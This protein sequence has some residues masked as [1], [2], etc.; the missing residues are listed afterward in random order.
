MELEQ[1]YLTYFHDLYRYLFSLTRNHSEAEDLVQ[2]TF[3]KA[4]LMLLTHDIKEIKPWLFK[5]GY[6]TFVDRIRKEKRN[7]V[8]EEFNQVD[9]NNPE[10]V[11]VQKDSFMELLRYLDHIKP[12]EKQAILLCDLHECTY[13]QAANI[14]NLKLN[15]LKSHLTRGRKKMREILTKEETNESI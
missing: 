14:L 11:M 6:H 7:V 1:I 13:Q 4:H 12:I 9:W 15:T 3:T 2:E 10:D 5:V 8:S